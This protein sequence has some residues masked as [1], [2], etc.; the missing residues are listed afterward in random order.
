MIPRIGAMIQ[1]MMALKCGYASNSAEQ[2]LSVRRIKLHLTDRLQ[3]RVHRIGAIYDRRT[4]VTDT[5]N[6]LQYAVLPIELFEQR[7]IAGRSSGDLPMAGSSQALADPCVHDP[8]LADSAEEGG[9][10]MIPL[11]K[12]FL[13]DR[14]FAVWEAAGPQGEV[15]PEELCPECNGKMDAFCMILVSLC[16][17]DLRVAYRE[18]PLNRQTT[19]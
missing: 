6:D 16:Q 14:C 15:M 4:R 8:V 13:C 3:V 11:P 10:T 9:L 1:N 19:P 5:R 7:S 12:D 18:L 2:R 17:K